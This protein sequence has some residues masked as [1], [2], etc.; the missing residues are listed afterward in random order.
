MLYHGLTSVPVFQQM[1]ILGNPGMCWV[2][3]WC[4]VEE[5][6]TGSQS[7]QTILVV[8]SEW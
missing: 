5:K 6:V 4:V 7:E 1:R 8:A 3:C 2:G